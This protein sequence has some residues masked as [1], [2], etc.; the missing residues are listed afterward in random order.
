MDE[1][2]HIDELSEMTEADWERLRD[3]DRQRRDREVEALKE[4]EGRLKHARNTSDGNLT[5]LLRISE[6]RWA[7][8]VAIVREEREIESLREQLREQQG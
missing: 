7:E 4:F 6:E 8:P 2:M 1:I 3:W 5:A